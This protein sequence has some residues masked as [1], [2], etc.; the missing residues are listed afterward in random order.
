MNLKES[1]LAV[2]VPKETY[3]GNPLECVMLFRFVLK[4]VGS[5]GPPTLLWQHPESIPFTFHHNSKPRLHP[6]AKD[7]RHSFVIVSTQTSLKVFRGRHMVIA[8]LSVARFPLP[9]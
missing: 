2:R 4:T 9:I 5:D 6:S 7:L 3:A 8:K 1:Q